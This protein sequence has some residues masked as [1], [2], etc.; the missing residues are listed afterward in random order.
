MPELFSWESLVGFLT[1][2]SLEIVLGI[3]NIVFIAILTG[4]LP[5]KMQA[6]A[7]RIG[8]LLA[9]A[10]RILLLLVLRWIMGLTEELFHLLGRGFSGHDLILLGGGLFLIAK[11][12]FEIHEKMEGPEDHTRARARRTTFAAVIIQ[13]VLIDIVFSLDS[14]ITAVG[15]ARRI[16]IMIAAIVVAVGVMLLF[17]GSVSRFIERHP[18]MKILALSFLVLI[19]VALV[20]EGLGKHFEKGYIY[21]AMAFSL[22]IELINLRVRRSERPVRLHE[23][24]LPREQPP[25]SQPD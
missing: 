20:A 3:D 4:R 16:E 2:A 22:L 24:R 12:T 17:A 5:V 11:A 15:M 13:I 23:P 21:F 14:V 10:T 25:L 18:T 8:L 7:Q 9:M 1:L 19:G 6:R